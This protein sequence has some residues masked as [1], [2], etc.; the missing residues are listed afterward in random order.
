MPERGLLVPSGVGLLL[1]AAI[2]RKASLNRAAT[3]A[4]DSSRSA[5]RLITECASSST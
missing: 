4:G 1:R 3:C 5:E 2:M